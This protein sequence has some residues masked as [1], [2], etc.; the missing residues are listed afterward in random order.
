MKSRLN[1]I[2]FADFRTFLVAHA[3]EM[4]AKK[5]NWSYGAW[6]KR[7]GLTSTSAISRV[8]GGQR[9]PGP[10]MVERLILYFGFNDKEATY[11]R[12]LIMLRKVKD[13]PKLIVLLMEKLQ[14]KHPHTFKSTL[15]TESYAVISN[16]YHLAIREMLSLDEFLADPEWISKR[17]QFKVTP[18]EVAQAIE[19]LI[20]VGLLTRDAEGRLKATEAKVSSTRDVAS[21]GIKRYHEQMLDNAKLA[22]RELGV[23]ER[24]F[25][26]TTLSFRSENMGKAKALIREFRAKFED[27]MEEGSGDGVYQLQFQL[28]PLTRPKANARASVQAPA[29]VALAAQPAAQTIG[30]NV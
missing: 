28:F 29:A 10:Q 11:F 27:L 20:R 7:L 18:R 16:W 2:H 9:E 30:A 21:E 5:P 14:K 26:A 17:F 1:I 3:Q 24:E 4:K 15:D 22:L 19:N 25:G 23:E 6:A 13:D 8:L 12:D